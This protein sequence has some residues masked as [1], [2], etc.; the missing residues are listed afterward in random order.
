MYDVTTEEETLLK[1]ATETCDYTV[2]YFN[3]DGDI[4]A[5]EDSVESPEGWADPENK[6]ENKEI[7]VPMPA[8][9]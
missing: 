7:V 4:V 9:G 6:V 2:L 5:Y 1:A 8:A 3:E